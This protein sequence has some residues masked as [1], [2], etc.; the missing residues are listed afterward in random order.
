MRSY[1]SF[2]TLGFR[3][4]TSTAGLL[5]GVLLGAGCSSK[6]EQGETPGPED[7]STVVRVVDAGLGSAG[8]LRDARSAAGDG[9]LGIGN[10]SVGADSLACSANLAFHPK[11]CLCNA[12]STASCW[13][14]LPDRRNVGGCH[15]GVQEC[16]NQGE[17]SVWGAC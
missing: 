1:L 7:A 14:G 17:F 12:G 10:I 4:V 16:Q 15:D 9:S 2:L 5:T 3:V 6:P 8:E 11:G 13:T